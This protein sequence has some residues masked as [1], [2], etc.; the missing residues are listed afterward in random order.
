MN[1]HDI[2]DLLYFIFKRRQQALKT[3]SQSERVSDVEF[4]RN[5]LQFDMK[6]IK[7]VIKSYLHDVVTELKMEKEI[8]MSVEMMQ[9]FDDDCET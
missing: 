1:L 4:G 2:M 5:H 9:T 6:R 3:Y 8:T 7:A